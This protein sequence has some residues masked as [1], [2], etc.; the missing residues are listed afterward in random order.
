MTLVLV[1]ERVARFLYDHGPHVD[2]VLLLPVCTELGAWNTTLQDFLDN[3]VRLVAR[4]NSAWGVGQ[5]TVMFLVRTGRRGVR[6]PRRGHGHR[7]G[8]HGRAGLLALA[9]V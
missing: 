9:G 8:A 4:H 5:S 6:M 7:Y 2:L 3:T 1:L